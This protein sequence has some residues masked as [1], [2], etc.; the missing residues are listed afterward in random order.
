MCKAPAFFGFSDNYLIDTDH[1]VI[2]GA[3][4]T[5]SI[6]Q[7]E[8]GSICA[9]LDRIKDLHAVDPERLITDAAYG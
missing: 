8:V 1:G 2:L 5:G 4:G 9:K 3:E 6:R 7:A